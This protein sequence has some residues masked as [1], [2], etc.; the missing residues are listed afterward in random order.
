MATRDTTAG[1]GAKY[2]TLAQ[3]LALF[4][5]VVFVLAGVLGFIP[6]I[7]SNYDD[8]KFAGDSSDAELL[9]LFQVSILHNIVHLLFGV[10]ILMARTWESAK[11]YLLGSGIV[12]VILVIWGLLV[13]QDNSA[14]F[15]PFNN[16]DDWLHA[17][18]A[19]GL[20]ASYFASRRDRDTSYDR[21]VGTTGAARV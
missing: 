20:L 10:G 3:K 6:G 13:D 4:W 5:G 9:G 14:N 12:Y 7:T 1:T 17:A 18:L 16:G 2:R 21:D 19:L 11:N 8:L 15:I